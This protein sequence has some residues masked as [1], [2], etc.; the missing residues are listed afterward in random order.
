MLNEM[1]MTA[2]TEEELMEV[3]GGNWI[4]D[5]WNATTKACGKAWDATCD[6]VEENKG[7]VVRGACIVGGIALC[8]TG[9]GIGAAAGLI[10]V[11]STGAAAIVATGFGAITGTVAGGIITDGWEN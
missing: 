2:L 1:K 8:A 6:W 5:A 7:M 3:N 10:V 9:I 11:E 4:T